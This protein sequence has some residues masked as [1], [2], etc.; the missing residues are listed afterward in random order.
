[1]S[2]E[3]SSIS[4]SP[5]IRHKPGWRA[6]S[7]R[8]FPGTPRLAFC[9]ETAKLH[10]DKPSVIVSKRWRSRRSPPH[11]DHRGRAPM[12]SESSARSAAN[13]SITSSSSMSITCAVRCRRIFSITATAGRI[14][15]WTR[16]TQS[17]GPYSHPPQALLSPFHRSAA[18]TIATSVAQPELFAVTEPAQ[19]FQRGG[20]L[21]STA[22]SPGCSRSSGQRYL[23]KFVSQGLH[24]Q[25]DPT[26][27]S[28]FEQGQV[29][30]GY[31][32]S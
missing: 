29:L 3:K 27:E 31:V 32:C 15:H 14:F 8:P 24:R 25:I 6:K 7:P 18:C 26:T 20:S 16:I 30:A 4:I 23:S 22:A 10:M 5:E 1:M 28:T 12:S 19:L 21:R 17:L 2:E 11:R 9:C 13:V